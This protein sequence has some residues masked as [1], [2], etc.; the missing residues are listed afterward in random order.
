MA[1]MFVVQELYWRQISEL[2]PCL[3]HPEPKLGKLPYSQEEGV[4]GLT[5][6]VPGLNGKMRKRND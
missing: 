2:V 1:G 4:K 3:F 5:L 6:R